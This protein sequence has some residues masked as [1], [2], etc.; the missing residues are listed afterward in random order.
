MAASNTAALAAIP[1]LPLKSWYVPP[2]PGAGSPRPSSLS[3]RLGS[4]TARERSAIVR[5][6]S[7]ASAPMREP[8][9]HVRKENADYER[10]EEP[11]AHLR[12]KHADYE[13]KLE[14]VQNELHLSEQ[15]EQGL[16]D[17]LVSCEASQKR[18]SR[19]VEELR[20]RCLGFE[21]QCAVLAMRADTAVAELQASQQREQS[22]KALTVEQRLIQAHTEN[23]E[24]EAQV[25]ARTFSGEAHRLD[26]ALAASNADVEGLRLQLCEAQD[27]GR[28]AKAGLARLE[29]EQA[30][31]REDRDAQHEALKGAMERIGALASRC[32]TLEAAAAAARVA[33]APAPPPASAPL[34]T[35]SLFEGS[36]CL[37][38]QPIALSAVAQQQPR[39]PSSARPSRWDYPKAATA[40]EFGAQI[41]SART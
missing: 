38:L 36:T 8:W 6:K 17:A 24:V 31:L 2:M 11:W 16:S 15:R 32:E 21:R 5:L 29:R 7:G 13:R 4:A 41:L 23:C 12:K 33:G 14:D 35:R 19:E 34:A 10:L 26:R 18:A 30:L 39:A 20:A 37:D 9:A 3:W 28:R 22:L 27:D 40:R 25:Q 1:Q